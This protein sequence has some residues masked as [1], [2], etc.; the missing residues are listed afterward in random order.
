MTI[1]MG[2]G[3]NSGPA[4]PRRIF[5]DGEHVAI[6]GRSGAGKST[7]LHLIAG[8]LVADAAEIRIGGVKAGEQARAATL[9]FQ[10]P[11]LLPWATAAENVQ[12]P[13]R[14]SGAYRRDPS[15]ARRKAL[16]LLE[17]VGLADRAEARR[18]RA[19][20]AKRSWSPSPPRR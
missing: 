16:A 6:V 2:H 13:L 14:F 4:P 8:L 15:A 18:R 19:A 3:R 7:V 12:L 17:Q 1:D 9:M 5:P 20:C 11:A 10:R